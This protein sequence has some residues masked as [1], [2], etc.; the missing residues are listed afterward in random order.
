M[1]FNWSG[2]FQRTTSG[3]PYVSGSTISSTVVNN[4]MTDIATGLSTTICK[5]GQS[6][7][8]SN[9]PMATYRHTGVGNSAART[10]YASAADVQDGT[11]IYLTSVS[12]TN[13]I[14]ATGANG[15]AAYAAGQKFHF[16]VAN[17][18]TGAATLNINSVGAKDITKNVATALTGGEL[19]QNAIVIVSYDGTQFQIET[20]GYGA[21]AI[22]G[23]TRISPHYCSK[24]AISYSNLSAGNTTIS[25]PSSTATAIVIALRSVTS[26]AGS[27]AQRYCQTSLYTEVGHSNLVASCNSYAYEFSAVSET[28]GQNDIVTVVPLLS[29]GGNTYAVSAVDVGGTG[30]SSYAIVG[31]FD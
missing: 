29:V 8:T 1:S 4:E 18:N 15:L 11:L 30:Q 14:T 28:L 21:A 22:S 17:T 31:Y 6:S 12:G 3:T 26:S 5:D 20:I 19:I 10:D 16:I 2:T 23:Y 9:L 24:N 7:P 13:T 27:A 25:A